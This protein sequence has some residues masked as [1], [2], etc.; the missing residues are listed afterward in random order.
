[1][2]E[3]TAAAL[4]R[5]LFTLRHQVAR[6]VPSAAKIE[7][8]DTDKD[9][10]LPAHQGAAAYIDGN[11]RTFLEKYTD[12]IWGVILVL[13]GLGSAGAWLRHYWRRDEREQF[14]AHRDNLLELIS[15]ARQAET[16]DELSTMQRQADDLLREAL[17]CYDAGAIE[18]DDLSVIGLTLEQFH[19]AIADRRAALGGEAPEMQRMRVG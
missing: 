18:E 19:H 12:Y 3:S 15:K 5:Q 8:P 17:D 9:A 7:K 16:P 2:S 11:E 10:S 6:D 14:L 4:T 1:M 13:S